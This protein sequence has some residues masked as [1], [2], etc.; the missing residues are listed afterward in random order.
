MDKYITY[1]VT[2]VFL[3]VFSFNPVYARVNVYI[4][5]DECKIVSIEYSGIYSYIYTKGN[6]EEIYKMCLKDKCTVEQH[7]PEDLDF[8]GKIIGAERFSTE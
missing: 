4:D 7:I 8:S 6:C 5:E 1:I 2:I 3:T